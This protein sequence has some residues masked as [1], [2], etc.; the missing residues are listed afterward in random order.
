MN[1]EGSSTRDQ[2]LPIDGKGE[3]EM[4]CTPVLSAEF[5]VLK[6]DSV[7][8]KTFNIMV[9][10]YHLKNGIKMTYFFVYITIISKK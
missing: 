3:E 2:L 1:V 7:V 9:I 10:Q 6:L 4:V 8:V 5:S